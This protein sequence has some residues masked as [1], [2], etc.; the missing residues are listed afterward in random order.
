[1]KNFLKTATI[2]LIIFSWLPSVQNASASVCWE[3]PSYSG[4]NQRTKITINHTKVSGSSALVNFPILISLTNNDLKTIANGGKVANSNGYDIIFT[5]SNGTTKFDHEIEKYNGSTGQFIGWVKIPSLSPSTDKVIYM[6]YGNS[7]IS[8][9]QENKTAVW[10]SNY[11]GVWH[12][13]N[14]SSPIRD[15]T[16]NGYNGAAFGTISFN[17]AGKINSATRYNS[18]QSHGDDAHLNLGRSLD[19]SGLPFTIS[20]W[21]NP[22]N[23]NYFHTI[24]AKRDS[25][26]PNDMRFDLIIDEGIY[27]N[28]G[29]ILL[30]SGFNFDGGAELASNYI[31]PA[32]QWTYVT[33]VPQVGSTNL[34]IN[35]QFQENI[36]NFWLGTDNNAESFVGKTPDGLGPD[37][38]AGDIDELRISSVARSADW[39]KTEYNNQSNPSGFANVGVEESCVATGN[40]MISATLDSQPWPS[41]GT[42]AI[43]YSLSGPS[44]NISNSSVPLTYEDVIADE[45]YTLTY[46]SGGPAGA[47]I[48]PI[49][50]I[51]PASSQFLPSGTSILFNLNFISGS[52]LC[53]LT[54]QSGRTIVS[55]EPYQVIGSPDYAP[56][57]TGPYSFGPP[58][59]IGKYDV[60]LVSYDSHTG[61][62]GSG[63]QNQPNEKYYLKLLNQSNNLITSTNS[64]A[65]IPNDQDF[66]TTVVNT[67]LQMSSKVYN[68]ET[69]HSAYIDNSDYNSLYP[70]CAAF[71]ESF[72]YSLS[73]SGTSNVTKTSSDAFTQNTITK[74]LT[75]GTTESVTLSL[76][77]VPAT[78]V[79]YTITHNPGDPANPC[80][81]ADC[82]SVINFTVTPST[83]VGTHPITVT[84]SPLDKQTSFDLV[85]SG[86]PLIVSCSASPLTV[87]L[88]ETVTLNANVSGGTPPY[89]YSWNGT[90]I[91]TNPSPDTNPFG[92]SY[93][94]VGQKSVS[95]TVT[96]SSSPPFQIAC[97]VITVRANID[98]QYKEF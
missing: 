8:T 66:I 17:A 29:S 73:N 43:N 55:F 35:G 95:V 4:Y 34:Y 7:S 54:P 1:M 22:D 59:A 10:D 44:G 11:K 79:S 45:S 96:D 36:G 80:N 52:N 84:G 26:S 75:S 94:T 61:P 48:N 91:P 5:D 37:Q 67:G 9:S 30:Q 24:F 60:T 15:S 14:A 82:Q 65:D 13:H 83:P 3:D 78:G 56:H 16:V 20:A 81:P 12:M 62:G 6:Y 53:P 92:I 23:F 46:F 70:I 76:S 71:D 77:G 25:Y 86:D 28:P 57:T 18:T 40:I 97:P 74:T 90:D 89:I 50:P 19:I 21:V 68:I 42:S 27:A 38:Y 33:V 64:T 39:I 93:N 51:S 63:S 31:L 98:P 2:L 49:S 58:L 69:W 41:S 47:I 87:L 88:G 32:G 72:N 85:V